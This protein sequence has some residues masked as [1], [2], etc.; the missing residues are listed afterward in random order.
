MSAIALPRNVANLPSVQGVLDNLSRTRK[1]NA[2]LREEAKNAVSP[3]IATVSIQAGAAANGAIHAFAGSW[4]P[5]AVLAAGVGAVLAGTFMESPE[6]VLF[7]NGV[8]APTVAAKSFE[9]F[10]RRP[11]APTAP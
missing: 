7:G 3:M 11:A 8:L 5:Q 4:T 10:T 1:R 9:L 6:A 2:A